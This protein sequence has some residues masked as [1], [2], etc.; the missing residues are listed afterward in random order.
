MKK[1][2]IAD[3]KNRL[4]YYLRF[5]RKGQSVMVYDRDRP[6]ARIDPVSGFGSAGEDDRVA[7]LVRQGVLR[8]PERALPPDWLDR[9]RATSA[10]V[11]AALLEERDLGR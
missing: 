4:S 8:A 5:V 10:D 9:R 2:G 6:V 1:T 11:V 7:E 3:L